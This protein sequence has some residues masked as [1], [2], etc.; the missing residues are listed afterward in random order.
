MATG[1]LSGMADGPPATGSDW[2]DHEVARTVA[3]YFAMLRSEL[4]GER[5]SKASH[6]RAL[7]DQL[8]GRSEQAVEFKHCNIS[9]VLVQMGLPY[10]DG[11][12]PRSNVQGKLWDAIRQFLSRHPAFLVE[13]ASAP[14]LAP[15]GVPE[16]TSATIVVPPPD[17]IVVPL[18]ANRPWI[19]RTGTHIDFAARDAANRQLASL[20]ESFIVRFEQQ[21]LARAGRADLARKVEWIADTCGDGVGFDVLSFDE[22]TDD[23]Q[24]LEVKTTGLGKYF[25]FAGDGSG[26]VNLSTLLRPPVGATH[27]A[28][29]IAKYELESDDGDDGSGVESAKFS[30]AAARL[31]LA[32]NSAVTI[33]YIPSGGG[34]SMMLGTTTTFNRGRISFN[35]T[36]N[37]PA[38]VAGDQIQ[39]L[40]TIDS[41]ILLEGTLQ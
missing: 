2:S 25:P 9:A 14:R 31:P 40:N 19:E 4:F 18:S 11:Y 29:G 16:I 7:V 20:G 23:E 39:V 21:R 27:S 38:L 5:Y 8:D 35:L 34:E 28:I 10:I 1:I 32:V 22:A 3:D 30:L 36:T 6:R 13:L 41:S 37:V 15:T 24:F 17:E 26:D 12:K 33:V